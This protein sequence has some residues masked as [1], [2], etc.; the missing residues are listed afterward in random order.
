MLSK[1]SE[2]SDEIDLGDT[3]LSAGFDVVEQITVPI[4]IPVG[5]AEQYWEWTQTHGARWLSDEL[6]AAAADEFR[7]AVIDSLL[8]K[9]PTQGRDIMVAPLFTK[10]IRH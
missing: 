1:P 10:L 6:D 7:N 9:H 4:S 2:M 3:V 5:G 8:E